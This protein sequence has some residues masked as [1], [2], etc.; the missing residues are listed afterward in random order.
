MNLADFKRKLKDKF[1]V[2]KRNE[3]LKQRYDRKAVA[4]WQRQLWKKE[5]G[6]TFTKALRELWR[7]NSY[8]EMM[9]RRAK[10]QAK[11]LKQRAGGVTA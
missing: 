1:G 8:A 11:I 10:K 3:N 7:A 6:F 2:A 5:K 4:R 9:E